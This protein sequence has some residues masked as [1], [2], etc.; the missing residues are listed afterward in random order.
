MMNTTVSTPV[1]TYLVQKFCVPI[2]GISLPESEQV[3]EWISDSVPLTMSE[4]RAYAR[5]L[6]RGGKQVRVI[7]TRTGEVVDLNPSWT[8]HTALLQE[9]RD[10]TPV[11]E[12]VNGVPNGYAWLKA[13]RATRE[14]RRAA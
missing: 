6:A 7:D 14:Q 9:A 8:Q 11:P 1:R 5:P 4:A 12:S 10:L 13:I 3:M 2:A